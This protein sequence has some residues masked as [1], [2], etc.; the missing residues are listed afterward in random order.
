MTN[1]MH[2]PDSALFSQA[3]LAGI[4]YLM[5]VLVA[6]FRLIY[7]PEAL[8]V[9]GDATATMANIAANTNLF[10]LG[11]LA[12]LFCGVLEIFLVLAIFYLFRH[13]NRRHAILMVL[14]S[15]PTGAINFI[16]VLNDGAALMFA[17]APAFLSAFDQG[18]REALGMLFLKLHEMEVLAVGFFWGLWLFPLGALI[19]RSGMLPK[20]L[21][22]WLIINGV[23][24]FAISLTG[25]F[26][27]QYSGII[28]S[29]ALPAQL[30]EVAF[31][32]WLLIRG[33]KSGTAQLSPSAPVESRGSAVPQT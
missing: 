15:L 26:A 33:A 13:V 7:I 9:T 29:F 31:M 22:Y 8:F 28:G 2:K 24:Y 3:R 4:L 17:S 21:G 19:I 12:D 14:L 25:L 27:P 20:A 6:P 1:T 23:A 32:L 5:L 18:Q 10:K 16:N 11:I 30:G